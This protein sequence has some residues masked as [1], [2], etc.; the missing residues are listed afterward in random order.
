MSRNI[1]GKFVGYSIIFLTFMVLFYGFRLVYYY[2]KE[3]S[4]DLKNYTLINY[5]IK[6]ENLTKNK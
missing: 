4:K 5:L 1:R 2:R 3:H 6:D